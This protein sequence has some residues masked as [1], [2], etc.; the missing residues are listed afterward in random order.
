MSIVETLLA[1]HPV[2]KTGR[3][4]DAFR[5]RVVQRAEQIGYDAAVN[6]GVENFQYMIQGF[7]DSLGAIQNKEENNAQADGAK[8]RQHEIQIFSAV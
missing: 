5:A 6:K 8:P 7:A 3:Q 2:R 1:A 4:K